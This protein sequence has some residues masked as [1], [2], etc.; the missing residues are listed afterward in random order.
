[1]CPFLSVL[2]YSRCEFLPQF[3]LGDGLVVKQIYIFLSKITFPFVVVVVVLVFWCLFWSY[4]FVCLFVYLL[5]F[6]DR[7]SLCSPGCPGTHSVD[8][9]FHWVC[10]ITETDMKSEHE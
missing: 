10:Y 1:M 4:L 7:V 6:Q 3:P 9:A 5:F 2:D 8:Q